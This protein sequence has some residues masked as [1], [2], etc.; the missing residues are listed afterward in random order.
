MSP[1]GVWLLWLQGEEVR[2]APEDRRRGCNLLATLLAR[3]L[4]FS[5]AEL[6]PAPP[7]ACGP[8]GRPVSGPI[9]M[10][11]LLSLVLAAA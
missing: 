11:Q 1:P 4:Y 7:Q 6:T 2:Q 8:W 10:A 5:G 3:P 9:S